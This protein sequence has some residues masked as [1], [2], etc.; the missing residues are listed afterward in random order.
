MQK[1]IEGKNLQ[2]RKRV[3]K[4]LSLAG[5]EAD[6]PATYYVVDKICDELNVPVPPLKRVVE[7]LRKGGFQAVPTHFSSRGVKT[8]APAR[9]MKEIISKLLA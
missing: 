3:L 1:E 7:E 8:D 6:S 2:K 4:L 9:A 5:G